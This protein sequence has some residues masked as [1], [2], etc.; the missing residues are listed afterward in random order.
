MAERSK[1]KLPV[2]SLKPIAIT[3][4]FSIAICAQG[5][6]T[7]QARFAHRVI[8][9][10]HILVRTAKITLA[11]FLPDSAPAAMR[12][13]AG[14][15]PL[16]ESPQPPMSR[17]IYRQQLQYLL[18][19]HADL[20]SDL[21][22]P[23]QITVERFHRTV[24]REEVISAIDRAL[25]GPG[26]EGHSPLDLRRLRFS[27]PVYVTGKD[28]GLQVIRIESDAL[29]G[30]T[31]FRLWTSKDPGN[32]PFNVTAPQAVSLPT[33][34]AR[35]ALAPGVIVTGT[36]FGMVMEPREQNLSSHP[37]AV[38]DL[39]G[40]QT[41]R[42]LHPGQPVSRGDFA[43]PVLV[44]PGALATLILQGSGFKIKTIVTPLEQGMLGQEVRVRNT[45]SR[46]VVEAKVVGRD[47]LLKAD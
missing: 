37:A 11:D 43:S 31:R 8:L 29:R 4:M 34:V 45:E 44:E 5:R 46:Q 1:A 36:D 33:L 42:P 10:G 20:L 22:L 28:A 21:S 41:R 38:A 39:A 12:A 6:G 17:M 23:P 25:G 30:E 7:V 2:M 26:L 3:V 27:T 24:T 15:I 13:Q 32:L 40:L 47:E 18:R 9:P 16:G 35:R 19:D 14:K